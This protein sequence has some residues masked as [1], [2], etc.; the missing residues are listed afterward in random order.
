MN[1]STSHL[2]WFVDEKMVEFN[3]DRITMLREISVDK[4]LPF[5]PLVYAFRSKYAVH[6]II[7]AAIEYKLM[8]MEQEFI[9]RLLSDLRSTLG[10][11]ILFDTDQS[12]LFQMIIKQV[13]LSEEVFTEYARAQNRCF[14]QFYERFCDKSGC[15]DWV[16][17][18]NTYELETS[19][20]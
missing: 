13:V 3:R 2:E 6:E 20:S 11:T 8:I 16:K 1:I 15:V 12:R 19:S 17:I 7:R 18:T 10:V 9:S 4:L 14:P 5:H